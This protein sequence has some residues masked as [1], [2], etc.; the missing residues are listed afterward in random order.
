M[1][2]IRGDRMLILRRVVPCGSRVLFGPLLG[3]LLCYVLPSERLLGFRPVLE[4][5]NPDALGSDGLKVV[6]LDLGGGK[7]GGSSEAIQII[8]KNGSEFTAPASDGMT[9]PDGDTGS[10]FMWLGSDGKLYAPGASVPADVTK[11]TAQ[12]AL[13]EQFSLTPGGTYYFDLSGDER[14]PG[15]VNDA[16]AG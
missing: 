14:I 13:S 7:L 3:H 5:L 4:V 8:V 10:Y 12:F 11:L 1:K 15:T 2:C 16:S 9:R 6:T